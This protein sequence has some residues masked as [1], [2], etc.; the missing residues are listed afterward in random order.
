M[1]ELTKTEERVMQVLWDL[2]K[3]FVKDIIK[4]M[5][6]DPKPPYNTISSVVRLLEKKGY[7]DY[8]AYGKTYEYFPAISKVDYRK[9]SFKK[10]F[11]GYFDNS[12]DSL[13]SF[14]VKEQK[15]GEGDIKKIQDMIDKNSKR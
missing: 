8:K 13:L 11:T 2:K 7:V 15:L 12:V 10:M 6:D 14:M 5:P 3:A 1:D 9:A 4:A